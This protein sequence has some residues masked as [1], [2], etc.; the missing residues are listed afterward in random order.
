MR[1][2]FQGTLDFACGIYALINALACTHN[3]ELAQARSLFQEILGDLP[4]QPA[5]WRAF[6]RNESD[7]YWLIRHLLY[8][9]CSAPPLACALEQ[10]FSSCLLPRP[11]CTLET[12]RGYLPE[13][14]APR[15]SPDPKKN[16]AEAAAVWAALEARL[17]SAS[18]PAG[19]MPVRERQAA[20]FRFH[21]FL[22]GLSQP[23]V[24][25]WTTAHC[26]HGGILRL[27]DA[28]AEKEAV[29][30]IAATDCKASGFFPAL[31]R[32]VPESLIFL[33]PA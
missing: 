18:D 5:L 20:I 12:A 31:I 3:L 17:A 11:G 27:H 19:R 8:R 16:Q 6:I 29:H 33:T 24:S 25:H 10:P 1:Q 30:H 14:E 4:A 2:Y 22:P 21:R 32:I 7:H 28:S 26:L 9:W 15:G 13:R 23:V